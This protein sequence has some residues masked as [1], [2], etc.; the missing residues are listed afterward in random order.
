M[1]SFRTIPH[2]TFWN[3]GVLLLFCGRFE[4]RGLEG[5][6]I[7]GPVESNAMLQHLCVDVCKELKNDHA[8]PCLK[9]SGIICE[10][11]Y[12]NIALVTYLLLEK[13]TAIP[14]IPVNVMPG[15]IWRLLSHCHD[16]L[17]QHAQ[18][19]I[20][21]SQIYKHS[22]ND[23]ICSLTKLAGFPTSMMKAMSKSCYEKRCP[24]FKEPHINSCSIDRLLH[25]HQPLPHSPPL[26]SSNPSLNSINLSNGLDPQISACSQNKMRIDMCWAYLGKTETACLRR[27]A[28][29]FLRCTGWWSCVRKWSW[30]LTSALWYFSQDIVW[31]H[32]LNSESQGGN[33][34]NSKTFSQK[35]GNAATTQGK[36][37]LFSTEREQ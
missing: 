26:S 22:G 17:E 15:Q 19:L 34:Q 14:A 27:L 4:N 35:K 9:Q 20:T 7:A 36:E 28:G 33:R 30:K 2:S 13:E 3:K 11:W 10:E 1:N 37:E 8:L 21:Q 6:I 16:V 12:S 25:I 24:F 32:I 23:H 29:F 18:I 5:R 31:I